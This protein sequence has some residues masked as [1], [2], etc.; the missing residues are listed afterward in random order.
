MSAINIQG[1]RK[2]FSY[3]DNG[4]GAKVVLDGINL[5]IESGQFVTFFGPNGCGKT[6][7]LKTLAGIEPYD[8]GVV[9]IDSKSPTEAN[10][11]IIFQNYGDSLMPWLTCMQNIL[12]PFSL[13]A[14]RKLLKGATNQLHQLL[15]DLRIELPLD[16]YAYQLSSGQQQLTAILRTL[17]YKPDVILM[18]E[19]FSALDFQTRR[20]MQNTLLDIWA[21]HKPTILFVSH[22]PEEAI[23]LADR[24]VLFSKLPASV[25]VIHDVH[26]ERPRSL[27]LLET[28]EFF[29]LKRQC[30]RAINKEVR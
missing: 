19:P 15:R 3:N 25:I 5:S 28:Q 4:T 2:S 24:L 22:D 16:N 27:D 14:R 6:T 8:E 30:L 21:R 18:D 13:R 17:L 12:F 10:T 26:F 20:Y 29:E 9:H 7:F 11:G 1:L 23:Y